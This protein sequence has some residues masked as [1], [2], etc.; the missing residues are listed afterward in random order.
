MY[1]RSLHE[2]IRDVDI[3]IAGSASKGRIRQLVLARYQKSQIAD[4][5]SR[6]SEAEGNFRVRP[7]L[8]CDTPPVNHSS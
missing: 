7:F 1:F 6:L 5:L 4:F 8:S 2:I 3:Q